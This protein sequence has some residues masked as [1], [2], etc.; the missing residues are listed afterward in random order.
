MLR[1]VISILA[2]L[3][4]TVRAPAPISETTPEE[5]PKPKSA[6]GKTAKKETASSSVDSDAIT[7]NLKELENKWEAAI[8]RHDVSVPR[9]LLADDF[10]GVYW[11]GKV[12]NK[13]DAL[14]F[15]AR[16]TDNYGS[17]VNTKLDVHVNSATM[18]GV[19]GTAHE[20]R[21]QRRQAIRSH[22]SV[23]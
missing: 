1:V 10:V 5:K 6:T 12:R 11:D 13:S 9:S 4:M 23:H 7:A 15:F 22:V 2:L 8:A 3:L 17:A 21:E 16:D 19:I 18:A 14:A 20:R